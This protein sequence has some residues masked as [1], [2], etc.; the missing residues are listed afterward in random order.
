[1]PRAID[2]AAPAQMP[3]E[4]SVADEPHHRLLVEDRRLP[5]EQLAHPDAG[6]DQRFGEHRESEPE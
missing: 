5:V 6:L 4:M 1:M 3:V 2:L